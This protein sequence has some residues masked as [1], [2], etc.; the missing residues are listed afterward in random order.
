MRGD[1]QA[2]ALVRRYEISATCHQ[3]EEDKGACSD[4]EDRHITGDTE[5]VN[6]DAFELGIRDR[7]SG[8]GQAVGTAGSHTGDLKRMPQ[9]G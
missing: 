8:A 3:G 7:K 6:N 5:I 9:H 4:R 1:R 2:N